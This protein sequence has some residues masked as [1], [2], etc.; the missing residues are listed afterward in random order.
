MTFFLK[1]EIENDLTENQFMMESNELS[2][3]QRHLLTSD[4][5]FLFFWVKRTLLMMITK[6]RP[7]VTNC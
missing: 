1:N 7:I 2:R 6:R 5:K 4:E 3:C